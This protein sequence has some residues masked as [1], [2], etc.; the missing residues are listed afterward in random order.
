MRKVL[1]DRQTEPRQPDADDAN[2]KDRCKHAGG[3]QEPLSG[4]M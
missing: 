3:S 1:L 4:K 2:D